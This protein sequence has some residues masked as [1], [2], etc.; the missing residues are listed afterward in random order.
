ML[1][2]ICGKRET[3][4][5]IE[6]EGKFCRECNNKRMME[7]FGEEEEYRYP[8]TA[9][10]YESDGTL[11]KFRVTHLMLGP[12]VEW[13]A[14][15]MKLPDGS[16][17]YYQFSGITSIHDRPGVA[18]S[19]FFNKIIDGVRYKSI[20]K[21]EPDH[22]YSNLLYRNGMYYSLKSAGSISLYEGEDNRSHFVVDGEE[23]SPQELAEM[24]GPFA[25][26]FKI[27]YRVC[28]GTEPELKPDT[29]LMPVVITKKKLISELSEEIGKQTENGFISYR[30]TA[31]V[32]DA[33]FRI[34][35]KLKMMYNSEN[36][37]EAVEAGEEMIRMLEAIQHDDDIFP[38]YEIN[39]IR[40]II[41]KI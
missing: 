35:E 8:E 27:Q 38:E 5:F 32:S 19:R 12:I 30:D 9:F 36:R 22:S 11:R 6:G 31:N 1:C 20:E 25:G 39:V 17:G 24:T 10:V 29:Y 15:E 23:F 2:D 13:N 7:L 26:G 21:K 34:C 18:A 14:E 40:V 4:I 33:V 41:E 16:G 28:D 3:V 37:E